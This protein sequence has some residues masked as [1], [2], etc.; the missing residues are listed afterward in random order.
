MKTVIQEVIFK[1]EFDSKFGK[2]YSFQVKYDDQV[3]VYTSKSKDQNKFIPGQEAEF[4][5]ETKTYTD[6]KT[7]DLKEYLVIKPLLQNR[8]SNFGKALSKE[9]SR[10]SGFAVSYAK[11][12]VVGGRIQKE[13]LA[14][15]AWILF[16]LMVA[17][18]RT[19][20]S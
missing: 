18:D 17:M 7:G 12:L 1:K 11:D 5:E 14:D 8:Q 6:K 3:A 13:E 9:K 20:E 16:E 19:L 4:T 15:Q 10:Y 2:M